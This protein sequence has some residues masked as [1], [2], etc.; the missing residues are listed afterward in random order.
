LILHTKIWVQ[1]K[2]YRLNILLTYLNFC[3]Y[4]D[5]RKKV[6]SGKSLFWGRVLTIMNQIMNR[7]KP[8]LY[9]NYP[10]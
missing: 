10:H 2:S 7:V 6:Q 3:V 9:R 1:V 4:A 5:T 8:V